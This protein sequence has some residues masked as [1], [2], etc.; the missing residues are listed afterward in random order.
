MPSA[1]HRAAGLVAEIDTIPRRAGTSVNV[2]R[3]GGGEGINMRAREAWFEVD[4]RADDPTALDTLDRAVQAI[5]M[6]V[7]APLLIEQEVIGDRPAGHLDPTHQLVRAAVDALGEVAIEPTSPSTSTDA[8]AAH[9]RGI[10][11]VAL[12]ITTG[13]GEHTVQEWID[14]EPIGRGLRALARTVQRYEER[15]A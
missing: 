7:E 9:A 4:L 12:G 15:C 8:N 1:I 5:L 14:V 13:S 10:P 3:I 2:G 6:T 11:A